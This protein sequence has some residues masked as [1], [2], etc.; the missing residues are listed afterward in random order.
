MKNWKWLNFPIVA[1]LSSSIKE[2]DDPDSLEV[3]QVTDA[4][5]LLPGEDE[6]IV[7]YSSSLKLGLMAI[8]LGG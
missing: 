8:I 2:V 7:V 6:Q 1:F 3:T 4:I 5:Q